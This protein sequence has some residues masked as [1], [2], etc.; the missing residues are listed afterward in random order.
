MQ[1]TNLNILQKEQLLEGLQINGRE[2]K[3][4]SH[5]TVLNVMEEYKS[6]GTT[7]AELILKERQEQIEKHGR[8]IE[9]DVKYNKECQLNVAA[10][11]LLQDRN[12]YPAPLDWS[13]KIWQKMVSKNKLKRLIIAGALIA[14]EIDRLQWVTNTEIKVGDFVGGSW[15]DTSTNK[16]YY[17]EGVVEEKPAGLFV[18]EKSGATPL[19]DFISITKI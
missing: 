19:S 14:A 11:R 5:E 8:T 10:V 18:V 15:R 2:V 17:V 12:D 7:G 3:E 4:Y 9:Q 16:T 1:H 6:I 13:N